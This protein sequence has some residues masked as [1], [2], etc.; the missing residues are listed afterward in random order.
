MKITNPQTTF[1]E[2]FAVDLGAGEIA[3]MSL[4][5]EHPDYILLLDDALARRT[6]IAAGLT[7]WGTLRVLLEAKSVGLIESVKPV[8]HRLQKTGMWVSE[9]IRRR[10]LALAGEW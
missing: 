8:I 2:W 9:D 4:A 3:A 5:L 6:A 1:S 10:I 7:V